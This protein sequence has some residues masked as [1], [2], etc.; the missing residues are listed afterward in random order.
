ML[1]INDIIAKHYDELYKLCK[2]NDTAISFSKTSEDVFHDLLVRAITKFKDKPIDEEE[3]LAYL[4]KNLLNELHFQYSRK[5]DDI[6]RFT[7]SVPDIPM[8]E[9]AF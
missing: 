6:L 4:R 5:K 3:G 1:K 9:E 8:N 7:D 2:N